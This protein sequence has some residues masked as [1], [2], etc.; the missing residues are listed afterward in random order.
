VQTSWDPRTDCHLCTP[1]PTSLVQGE[2]AQCLWRQGYRNRQ[3]SVTLVLVCTG[4]E[5]NRPNSSL[6]S[7]PVGESAGP[8]E[9]W[10]LLRSQ[11]RLPSAHSPDPRGNLIVPTVPIGCKDLRGQDPLILACAWSW[12]TVSRSGATPE[13]RGKTHF[14]A[15]KWP[16]WWIQDTQ[17]QKYSGSGHFLFLA[18]PWSELIPSHSSLNPN[19]LGKRADH[20][21]VQTFWDPRTDR[22]LC[23][24]LPT[25][26]VQGEMEECLWTQ[27]YRNRQPPV[28]MVLVW[29]QDWSEQA[30]QLPTPKSCGG[31]SWTLRSVDTPQKSEETT[32]CPQSTPKRELHG[33]NCAH[34]LQGPGSSQGQ[35]PLLPAHSQSWKTVSRSADTP[36]I[37]APVLRKGR[38]EAGKQFYGSADTEAYSRASSNSE[39]QQ[40]KQT[41]ETTQWLEASTGT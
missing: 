20:P 35:D 1:L 4:T 12:K 3:P 32:L 36:E 7:N 13:S 34:C 10:T 40:D 15:T 28:P 41:P 39:K 27:A 23:T 17:R 16:A 2:T 33:G 6:H 9:V 24:P 31:K 14:S 18:L 8:S 30:K 22:H 26:L 37:R 29:A 21:G 11:R 19:P 5:L 38:K 25:S